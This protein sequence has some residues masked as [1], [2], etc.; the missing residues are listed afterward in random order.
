MQNRRL[1]KKIK[2]LFALSSVSVEKPGTEL[3]EHHWVQLS[4]PGDSTFACSPSAVSRKWAARCLRFTSSPTWKSHV[5]LTV[6]IWRI[7]LFRYLVISVHFQGM[8]AWYAMSRMRCP[9]TGDWAARPLEDFRVPVLLLQAS[10]A[11]GQ[12]MSCLV[13]TENSEMGPPASQ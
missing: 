10:D 11:H 8:T 4:G 13:Y 5:S 3:T 7:S 1:R 12:P 2:N 6:I 9:G